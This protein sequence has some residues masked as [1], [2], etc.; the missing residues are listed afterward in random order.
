MADNTQVEDT[1]PVT[2]QELDDTDKAAIVQL[3]QGV[4]R[5]ERYARRQEVRESRL[6]RFY[7]R[8]D[9]YIYF[10]ETSYQFKPAS[11]SGEQLPTYTDVYNI[12]RPHSRSLIS[13]LSQNPPGVNAVP[14]DLKKSVDITKANRAEKMRH[15][16][17]RD[18]RMKEVQ[19]RAARFFCTDA[20]V[21]T[22]QMVKDGKAVCSVNGVLESKVPIYTD[23]IKAW[24]YAVLSHERDVSSAKEEYPD[25]ADFITASNVTSGEAAF[26]R[27]ARIGVLGGTKSYTNADSF[28]ELVTEHTAWFRPAKY[29]KLPKEVQAKVK[30]LYPGG[31]RCVVISD[32]VCEME[33][34]SIDDALA[35]G[36]PAPGDGQNRPSLLKDCVPLQD[37]F[38]D[39]MNMM[40]E[41]A[42]YCIPATWYDSTGIDD[43]AMV[44]QRSEPG[45]MHGI[46]VPNGKSITDV[47]WQETAPQLPAE[48]TQ[49]AETISGQLS[50][51]ITGD[52]PSLYGGSMEDV[53]TAKGYSMARE[54]AMGALAPAWSAMQMLFATIYEQLIQALATALG[55]EEIS[56]PG[57]GGKADSFKA[58]E[59]LV[60]EYG[61]Y[62]DTDSSFPETTAAKRAA[63]QNYVTQLAGM[64]GGPAI[65][66]LP[67]NLKLGL[68]LSGLED[69]VIPGAEAR[70][71]QL[72]E[73]EQLLGQK[74]VPPDPMAVQQAQASGQPPPPPTPSVPID[75]VWDYHQAEMDKVQEWLS[76]DERVQEE[77]QGN[78][79]G[80]ENVKLHGQA[81]KDALAAQQGQ[82]QGKPPSVSIAFGDVTDPKAQAQI[83]AEAG[84]QTT[85]DALQEG[86]GEADAQK[87]M[88]NIVPKVIQ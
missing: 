70:D 36:F 5:E 14:K 76:S 6:Q 8:G 44:E 25:S 85:P 82:P 3:L 42:D 66:G 69:F 26:E 87:L 13:V 18:V 52:L 40:R 79:A 11:E 19:T 71:K 29:R 24:P 32:H 38:N 39:F 64:D 59:L 43:E 54:Q 4:L 72:R 61:W 78:L 83:L 60:G 65:I 35:V 22:R 56:I 16:V 12:Y 41:H 17:D 45:A 68:Q 57:D 86:Q 58:S 7:E 63:Y 10:D 80:I 84:I 33:A 37:A 23:E 28:A 2:P 21:V 74:P 81:H 46:K 15:R 9:Q 49:L 30:S 77:R 27:I 48:V 62:P 88:H 73:I 51:F 31:F 34:E 55:D 47:I 20:R 1:A 53:D 50:Q 67:D 75:P